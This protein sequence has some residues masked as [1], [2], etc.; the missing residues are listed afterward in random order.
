MNYISELVE[1]YPELVSCQSQITAAK[2]AIVNLYQNGG[3][4]LICGN[5]GSCADSEHMIGELMKGF[6]KKRPVNEALAQKLI[7]IRKEDGA[8]LAKSLQTPLR[9]VSLCGMPSLGTATINDIGANFT[10]AQQALGLT[11][12]GDIFLG[13][14]ASGNAVNIHLAAITA[15]AL[16]ALLV[17]LTGNDGGKMNGMYDVLIK[18]PEKIVYK[19]QELHLAVYHAIC[20][21][22]EETFF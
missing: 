22:V 21:D 19:V 12:P 2:D 14:S 5:G 15:K 18:V 1:R 20:L 4:I 17:G 13:I 11:D 6:L 9:A 8:L 10:Y 16:G 3:K 7:S